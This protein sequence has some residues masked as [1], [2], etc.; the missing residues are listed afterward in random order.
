MNGELVKSRISPMVNSSMTETKR[1]KALMRLGLVAFA[2]LLLSLASRAELSKI[3]VAATVV[4]VAEN[5]VNVRVDGRELTLPRL[6]V[7]GRSLKSGEAVLITF[8]GKQIS[9]LLN[10]DKLGR[11]P[12]SEKS[13]AKPGDS[14]KTRTSNP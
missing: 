12:A 7:P 3:T 11:M 5:S 4:S 6:M 10:S 14:D 1:A 2:V 13:T 8:R 9:Y